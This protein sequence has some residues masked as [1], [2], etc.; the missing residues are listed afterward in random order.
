MVTRLLRLLAVTGLLLVPAVAGAQQGTL[1][2][3][4]GG[5]CTLS[6]RN[7]IAFDPDAP[8]PLN[9]FC[10]GAKRPSGT[11]TAI[12]APL[13]LSFLVQRPHA[14]GCVNGLAVVP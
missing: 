2:D 11:I 10:G 13:S 14:R 4:A 5:A 3:L 6:P 8:P 7:D 12:V 1:T 9:L